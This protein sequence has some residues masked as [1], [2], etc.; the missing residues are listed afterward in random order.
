M[1]K[2]GGGSFSV[3]NAIATKANVKSLSPRDILFT[4]TYLI[5]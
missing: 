1:C 4:Q 3:W 5:N 2:G